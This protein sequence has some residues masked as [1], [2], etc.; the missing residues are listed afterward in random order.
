VLRKFFIF[1]LVVGTCIFGLLAFLVEHSI[2]KDSY[3][4]QLS[5]TGKYQIQHVKVD[6]PF[7]YTGYGY[8]RIV[9]VAKPEHVYRSPIVE[10][11]VLD[12]RSYETTETVGIYW[13]DFNK[14]TH[15]FTLSFPDW[16]ESWVNFFISNT[17]YDILS[18]D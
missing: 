18:S 9:E 4:S 7:S 15:R 14:A 1:I 8:V 5:P 10:D 17:P 3:T 16:E 2:V 12:M 6:F 13:M 11:D